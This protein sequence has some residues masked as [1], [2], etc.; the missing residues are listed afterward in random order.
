MSTRERILDAAA[1]VMREQGVAHATTKEI[2]RAAGCSEA[3]L[4][5]HFD[6]KQRL[7]MAVLQERLPGFALP[8]G[9]V[10]TG[11]V[12]ANLVKLVSGLLDFYVD[13]FPISASIFSSSTLLARHREAIAA[14]GAGPQVPQLRLQAYL[15]AEAEAGRVRPDADVEAVARLLVGAAL[16]QAF[17]VAFWG[18]GAA[19]EPGLGKRLV[20]PVLP[21]LLPD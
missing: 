6:D 5:R 3:L 20:A 9:A 1:R 7:F 15:E 12:E 19:D 4:Y 16:H 8:D 10:G 13:S 18:G 11:T 14:H 17:L 2:A 21:A